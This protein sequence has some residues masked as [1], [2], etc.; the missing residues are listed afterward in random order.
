MKEEVDEL[1]ED[2]IAFMAGEIGVVV[3][4]LIYN[5]IEINRDNIVGFL[6]GKRKAVKN[7][8][9]KGLLRD[10]AELMRKGK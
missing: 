3:I 9:H 8:I 10:T 1:K 6:E 2:R 4:E 5:S 7:T